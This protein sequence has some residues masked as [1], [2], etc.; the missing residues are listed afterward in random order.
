L[1]KDAKWT[2]RL[3]QWM[4]KQVKRRAQDIGIPYPHYVRGL[5]ARDLERR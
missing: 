4:P 2:M 3:P 5:I 1:E